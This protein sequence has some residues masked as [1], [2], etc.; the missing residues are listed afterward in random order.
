MLTLLME[1]YFQKIYL[2]LVRIFK[3]EFPKQ[4]K[5]KDYFK[6]LFIHFLASMIGFVVPI[7]IVSTI[8]FLT[9]YFYNY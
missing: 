5:R 6:S 7:L 9:L 8:V 2:F 3:I 4:W 1:E